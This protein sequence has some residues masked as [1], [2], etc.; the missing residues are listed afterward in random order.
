MNLNDELVARVNAARDDVTAVSI[1]RGLVS[2]PSVTGNEEAAARWAA[3]QLREVM[4]SVEVDVFAPNRANTWATWGSDLG[5]PER[6]LL[7]LGHL[8]TVHVRGWEEHWAGTARESPYAAPI[9]DGAVWGRGVADCKGGIAVVIAA[10][11]QLHRAG[12]EPVRPVTALFVAD[13]ESGEEGSGTSEGIRR[14]IAAAA[15]GRMPI[16]ADLAIYGEP[17][18]M[19][20]FSSHMGFFIT[21]VVLTGKSAYFGTPELGVDALRAGD[22][23]LR[24]LWAHDED[25]RSRPA[26]PL[27]GTPSLLVTGVTGGGSVAVPGECRLSIIRKLTPVED[28]ATARDELEWVIRDAISDKRIAVSTSYPAS[29]DHELGGTALVTD[30]ELEPVRRLQQTVKQHLPD[31]GDIA[32]GPYWSEGPFLRRDLGIPTVYLAPGDISHC[33]TFEEHVKVDEYLAAVSVYL[34]FI[35]EYCGVR[36][37]GRTAE[38]SQHSTSISPGCEG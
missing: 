4:S 21:D 7:F 35:V 15:D 31:R 1:L 9:I 27:I 14:A 19:Q 13:E 20:V 17:T 16:R 12:L 5:S 30:P 18:T 38:T 25:L 2:I 29:R 22:E 28:L 3:D 6:G 26:D 32:A 37:L 8:D 11:R 36:D 34:Q 33:H 23:V 10:L 24:A